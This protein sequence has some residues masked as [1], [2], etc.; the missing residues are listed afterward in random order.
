MDA[1]S[2]LTSARY[3]LRISIAHIPSIYLPLAGLHRRDEDGAKVVTQASD[4]VVEA[5]PRSSNTFAVAAL[6][7]SQPR[8]LDIAHHLHAPAQLI[9]AVRL[10]K[11]ALLIVR[12]P[13]AAVSSF[14]LRHPCVSMSLG[15]KS[16]LHFHR[17]LL[18]YTSGMAIA[19]FDQVTSDL[20]AVIDAV[21][22]RFGT[23]FN[24][25]EHTTA[26]VEKLFRVL[27][28]RDKKLSGDEK[29]NELSVARPS[30]ERSKRMADL[31]LQWQA[32]R[33]RR[34]RE[35]ADSLYGKFSA[36][37]EA[38]DRRLADPNGNPNASGTP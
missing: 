33:L 5:F 37:A 1:R 34:Q 10:G 27:E 29:I 26:N 28:S 30:I 15:L 11:P 23:S 12:Q 32:A 20:G 9:K 18:P 7:S 21:N 16:W 13:M 6:Q 14:I 38:S 8:K 31:E 3:R 2:L 22:A 19:T 24:R 35:E 25:F 4:L 36:L 17:A